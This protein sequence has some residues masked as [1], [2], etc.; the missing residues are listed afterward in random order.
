MSWIETIAAELGESAE[1][2]ASRVHESEAPEAEQRWITEVAATV[3]PDVPAAADDRPRGYGGGPPALLPND[4]RD[5]RP[6]L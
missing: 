2:Y 4:S 1:S 5:R 6:W 3:R